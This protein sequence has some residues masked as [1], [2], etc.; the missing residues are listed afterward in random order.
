VLQASDGDSGDG[1][2]PLRLWQIGQVIVDERL[3][4]VPPGVDRAQLLIEMGIYDRAT[5]QRV[6]VIEATPPVI[7]QALLL[8]GATAS[9]PG[10]IGP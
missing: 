3:I 10:A 4:N 7:D 5:N 6:N 1:F 9:G 8:G 2:F